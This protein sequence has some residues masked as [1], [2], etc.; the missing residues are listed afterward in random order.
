MWT[1]IKSF[2][3]QCKRVWH[4]L[5]KPSQGE[6]KLVARISAIGIG[7]VGFIGFVISAFMN[8]VRKP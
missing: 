1:K 8:L 5:K 2:F 4:V 3:L 6:L 7:I